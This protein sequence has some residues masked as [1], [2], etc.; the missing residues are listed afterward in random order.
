TTNNNTT[1]WIFVGGSYSGNLAVW[2]RKLYPDVVFAS[3]ASSAPIQAKLDFFEYDQIVAKAL[4]SCSQNVSDVYTKTIDPILTSGNDTAISELKKSF[5]LEALDIGDFVRALTW[6][7]SI[8]VQYH[9]PPSPERPTDD[10][11]SYCDAFYQ[12]PATPTSSFD[13]FVNLTT[14]F[15]QYYGINT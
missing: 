13:V 7:I 4:P 10:L 6:P 8:A 14:S 11:N 12:T 2:I 3:Y 5:G 1:R 15:F 9:L